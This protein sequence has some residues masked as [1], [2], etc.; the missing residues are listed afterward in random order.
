MCV[1]VD[2]FVKVRAVALNQVIWPADKRVLRVAFRGATQ[3]LYDDI[4]SVAQTWS[5][6]CAM[7]FEAWRDWYEADIRVDISPDGQSWSYLG[8][9]AL[10]IPYEE[11][12]MHYGWLNEGMD[13]TEMARVVLHEFGHALGLVHEHQNPVGGIRWNKEEVYKFYSNPPHYWSRFMVDTNIFQ[14]YSKDS[15]NFTEFDPHSIML[16]PIP[17]F[18][19]KNGF[20]V[21]LNS[22]I[23]EKDARLVGEVYS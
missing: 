19:T 13:R 20:S 9:Q 1:C 7:R 3:K 2:R 12:T 21:G 15:T 22:A 17:A 4:F 23:S 11:P 14:T 16:Y 18:M 8:N 6:H 5:T 10:L